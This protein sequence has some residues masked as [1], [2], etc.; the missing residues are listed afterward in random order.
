MAEVLLISETK[1]KEI[2]G[3][4]EN[5][6][7]QYIRPSVREAQNVAFRDIIGSALLDKLVQ[8]VVEGNGTITGDENA[9]YKELADRAEYFLA[10]SAG[11][12][13]AQRVSFKV[14]NAGVIKTPDENMVVAEQPDM[15]KAQFF[16][17]TQA[18]SSAFNLEKWI[19]A[20]RAAFPELRD[21]DCGRI[22]SHLYTAA[23]CGIYLGGARGK[24]LPGTP[25]NPHRR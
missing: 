25:I 9:A 19:L 13:I 10:Y 18:D 24:I 14:A 22:H 4:S 15:A 20:N 7:G 6:A 17:Q 1:V 11:V 2:C 12:R 16:Y 21:C 23:S 8:L 3:F 5:I